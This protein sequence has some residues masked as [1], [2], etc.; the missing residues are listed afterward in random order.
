MGGTFSVE[1]H[2]V[3]VVG[4]ARSGIAAAEL[5]KARGADVTL[6]EGKPTFS[7]AE[8]LRAAGVR[9]ELGG[10]DPATFLASDLVVVSPGVPLET[11]A[12]L[13]AR[14][15][16][17][18]VIG[19]IELASR[20]LRGRIV[21]I[22]G[23]KGKSTT[24]TLTARMLA[25]SG[26]LASAGGN[27]GVPLSS[28]VESSTPDSLHVIE[29]SSFQLETTDT[30]HPWIAA[31]LNFSAD[32]LDRHPDLESYGAAKAR[33]FMHQT[34]DD[35]AVVNADD[36]AAID[37]AAGARSRRRW[38]G[39][40]DVMEGVTVAGDHVVERGGGETTPLVPLAAVRVAGRHTLADVLA[41]A[42]VSRLAGASV[43]GV[44]HAIETFVG[45]E[46]AME[47][48][49]TID[50]VRFIND[51]KA[52][53]IGAAR[54]AAESVST[55]LAIVLGGRLKAGD[56]AE[57]RDAL[58]TRARAI[59]AIGESAPLVVERLGDVAPTTI[60]GSM[61]EAVRAGFEAV[62]PRGTVLLAPA[63]ASFDMFA[64]FAERG[65]RFKEE[66]ARLADERRAA[67]E[68]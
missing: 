43:Q 19:E 29:V 56:F 2:R 14:Q 44:A 42:A 3:T 52:T 64:D 31:L 59:V 53:T 47:T 37:L 13:E 58:K 27:I 20:W 67:G 63:C 45:I 9:L 11:P 12:V 50:G 21:A 46:H 15:A 28:Q 22:T 34:A 60:V 40:E 49:D 7:E 35:W 51:S 6:S 4:A 62:R 55:D 23:T 18:P 38:F 16:G 65:R 25:Q 33:I 8:R 61:R 24:T 32:H 41:A 48:V 30:F 26:L 54:A 36:R 10:H 57:L 1:G 68:Q 5:L 39:F 66:V 17:V